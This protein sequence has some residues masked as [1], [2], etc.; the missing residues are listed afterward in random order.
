MSSVND[1]LLLA[2]PDDILDG[3]F[4]DDGH[5]E[6]PL[7]DSGN[8]TFFLFKAFYCKYPMCAASATLSN[9]FMWVYAHNMIFVFNETKRQKYFK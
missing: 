4:F 1:V 2:G 8:S 3:V 5:T 6:D 7:F 9:L